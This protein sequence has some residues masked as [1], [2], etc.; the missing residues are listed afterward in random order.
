MALGLLALAARAADPT[1]PLQGSW[2]LQIEG[3]NL[4]VL[5]LEGEAPR[6]KG[7]IQLPARMN[8]GLMGDGL[9]VSQVQMPAE[10]RSLEEVRATPSGRIF[11]ARRPGQEANEFGLRPDGKGGVLFFLQG[12][13]IESAAVPLVRVAGGAAVAPEWDPGGNWM[14][15]SPP[16]PSNAEMAEIFRLDQADRQGNPASIDWSVIGP[17][18]E[19]RRKRVRELLDANQLRTGDDF[20]LAAFVFQHGS[21]SEDYLLAHILAMAAQAKG[22]ADAGWI[23]TA[24]LDRYLGSI[25]QPQVFGTQFQVGEDGKLKLGAFN[26]GFLPDSVRSALGVAT[27]EQLE[28]QMR[29]LEKLPPAKAPVN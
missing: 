9:S 7:T 12:P 19:A 3:R 6:M 18:D 16:P 10:T 21:K 4:V 20:H 29:E 13:G 22:R 23:A 11:A 25:Q 17:R 28:A 8:L 14:V 2:A 5:Q 27:R 15:R 1:D 26:D 24:T